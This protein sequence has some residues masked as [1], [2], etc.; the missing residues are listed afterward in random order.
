MDPHGPNDEESMHRLSLYIWGTHIRLRGIQCHVQANQKSKNNQIERYDLKQDKWETLKMKLYAGF[1]NGNVVTTSRPNEV[2]ILGGKLTGGNST[3]VWCYDLLNESV[4]NNKHLSNKSMLAKH[5]V[6]DTD[7][8]LILGESDAGVYFWENYS[9]VYDSPVSKGTF[10]LPSDQLEKFKQYNFNQPNLVVQKNDDLRMDFL[11]RNYS[12]KSIIFGTDMEPFQMEVDEWTGAIDM[13]SIP[14]NLKLKNHHGICRIDHNKVFLA[15][16]I[17]HDSKK[18]YRNALIYDLNERTISSAGSMARDR[19]QFGI[20]FCNGYV[21][22][23]GGRTYGGDSTAILG[24][25]ERFHL[26]SRKW[27]ELPNLSV[28]RCKASVFSI[29]NKIFIAGGYT[30]KKTRTDT[31]EFWNEK[32]FR[33]ERFNSTLSSPIE[34]CLSHVANN[35]VYF[36]GGECDDGYSKMKQVVNVM[37]I[38]GEGAKRLG[39]EMKYKGALDKMVSVRGYL[40]IFGSRKPS[41]VDIIHGTNMSNITDEQYNT[42]LAYLLFIFS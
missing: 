16:G 10:D 41:E 30:N 19:H 4:V 14:S 11:S 33:W 37:D 6:L 31:I 29:Q 8:F 12:Q 20:I 21:Y 18:I 15:G 28:R 2:A 39:S 1:E 22:C 7:Q 32:S 17:S 23:L 25:G 13:M 9:F 3:R 5:M 26:K 27:Q 24:F 36:L 42:I 35:L 40:F 34:G 38:K